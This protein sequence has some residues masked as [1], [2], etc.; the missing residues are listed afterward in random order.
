VKIL[1]YEYITGGG[2]AGEMLPQALVAEADLMVL[3]L[4]SDLREA[5]GVQ[6][7]FTRDPRLESLGLAGEWG[8]DDP[9]HPPWLTYAER[10]DAVWPIAPETG[11]ILERISA[12]VIQADKILLASRPE[13]VSV[14]AS[15]TATISRLADHGLPVVPT[16]PMR[17][18]GAFES[19][20]WVLKPDDGVGCAGTWLCKD[21]AAL[22]DTWT[23][24]GR[25]ADYI[26]QP[27]VQGEPASLSLLCE[28]GRTHLLSVNRQRISVHDQRFSLD[29]CEV[30]ALSG[31]R[32]SVEVLAQRL[33]AA[34]PGLWG[35]V[36]VDLIL[37]GPTATL[38]EVNPRLTTAYAG[39]KG[40]LGV[41]PAQLV[42]RLAAGDDPGTGASANGAGA[43]VEVSLRRGHGN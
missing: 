38:L 3:A 7:A 39:L 2:A 43:V 13:A 1:V 30:N 23:D 12:S 22:L 42:L 16:Y 26:A 9:G 27:Y 20:P 10:I 19:G 4:V 34:L 8:W 29:A 37:D 15:K 33:G 18:R 5:P 6:V 32:G 25:P 31:H 14:C 40:A 41:N 11:G 17:D 35:Y 21:G 36:G 24:L 28:E